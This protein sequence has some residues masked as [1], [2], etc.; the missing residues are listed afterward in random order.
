MRSFFVVVRKTKKEGLSRR[1]LFN[2]STWAEPEKTQ[3]FSW[4][5]FMDK[6]FNL[7]QT[8]DGQFS[9]YEIEEPDELNG[10]A[11]SLTSGGEPPLISSASL[12]LFLREEEMESAPGKSTRL[13]RLE[14]ERR[15]ISSKEVRLFF[16]DLGS[17]IRSGVLYDSRGSKLFIWV[18]KS[19]VYSRISKDLI[20]IVPGSRPGKGSELLE[21]NSTYSLDLD[22]REL[23]K[24]PGVHY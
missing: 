18:S 20:C 17:S 11:V 12:T 10:L 14:D 3:S 5:E 21:Y 19:P 13:A 1:L 6:G 8:R 22:T 16:K 4:L 15:L 24:L 9:S 2:L 23:R 7:N